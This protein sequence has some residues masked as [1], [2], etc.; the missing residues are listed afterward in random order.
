VDIDRTVIALLALLEKSCGFV[1]NRCRPTIVKQMIMRYYRFMQLKASYPNE[2]FIPTLDIEI[3][4]QT[5]L[6][7]PEMYRNDCLRLFRRII[8]HSL[9]LNDTEESLKEQAFTNTCRLYEERFGEQYCPSSVN[10]EENEARSTYRYSLLNY[11][12][13]PIPV[14]SYWDDTGFEFAPEL[15]NNYENPFSFVEADI[16]LDGYWFK[17]YCTDMYGVGLRIMAYDSQAQRIAP[18]AAM[19]RLRKTY[20]RFL[21]MAAKYSTMNG[22]DFIHPTSAVRIQ[23]LLKILVLTDFHL[24]DRPCVACS[25]AGTIE[26]CKRLQSSHWICHGSCSLVID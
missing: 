17:L 24:I 4:W 8:N 14:Y 18:S 12:D 3:V 6:L 9:L 15:S 2:R 11:I 7:R 1:T 16:I 25:Y 23:I 13:C 20:E 19:K 22:Y 21:Y 26:I 10:D 5:H